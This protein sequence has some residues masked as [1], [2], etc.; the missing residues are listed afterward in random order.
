MRL[1]C[2][3]LSFGVGACLLVS[4]CS[5][6][7]ESARSRIVG[8]WE[9]RVEID[10]KAI[11][12]QIEK[13]A[14]S[15]GKA[16]IAKAL[17]DLMI[18]TLEKGRMVLVFRSN[19]T[20]SGTLSGLPGNDTELTGKWRILDAQRD[21]VEVE[22]ESLGRTERAT[23]LFDGEDKFRFVPPRKSNS[24]EPPKEDDSKKE[25]GD[26]KKEESSSLLALP[27]GLS[28]RFTRVSS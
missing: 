24:A 23:F 4:G 5:D 19:G 27:K 22:L 10:K 18:G 25:E 6:P 12:A 11:E 14:K 1:P 20:F 15:S 13:K 28:F 2:L 7:V 26:S 9:G 8:R 3:L 16:A 21:R 17:A